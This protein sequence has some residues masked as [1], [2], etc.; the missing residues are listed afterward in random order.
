MPDQLEIALLEALRA[1]DLV[2]P[3]ELFAPPRAGTSNTTIGI[4]AMSGTFVLKVY[5]ENHETAAI[6]YEHD[7]LAWLQGAGLSCAVPV[8]LPARD[9]LLMVEAAPG[10]MALTPWLAGACLD[11]A[12]VAHAELL[13]EAMAELQLALLR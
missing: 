2:P 7:L 3:L 10:R 13:G 9:G 5:A 6:H 4:R 8:P 1:Y 11:P 12:R